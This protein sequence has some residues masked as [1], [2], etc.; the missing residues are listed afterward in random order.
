MEGSGPDTIVSWIRSK[1]TAVQGIVRTFGQKRCDTTEPIP[2]SGNQLTGVTAPCPPFGVWLNRRP[3][4][5]SQNSHDDC[6][7]LRV[8]LRVPHG[9]SLV[10]PQTHVRRVSCLGMPDH[11]RRSHWTDFREIRHMRFIWESVEKIQVWLKYDKNKGNLHEDLCKFM[12]SR[13]ILLRM[14]SVSD[15][16]C[17]ENQ[18]THFMFNNFVSENRAIYEIMWKNMVES[19]RPHDNII[20]CM[21]VCCWGSKARIQTHT[22]NMYYLLLVHCNNIENFISYLTEHCSS[23][24]KADRLAM[25]RDTIAVV[26][27]QNSSNS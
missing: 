14:R 5:G 18:H 9:V 13:L 26:Y 8:T 17:R 4:S 6:G 22:Q 16:S 27:S 2:L 7:D 25:F 3:Q 20:R 12:I 24:W 19:D 10:L 21:L 23:I 1:E 15:R 11:F